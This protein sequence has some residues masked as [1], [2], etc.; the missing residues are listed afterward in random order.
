[1]TVFDFRSYKDFLLRLLADTPKSGWGMRSKFASACGCQ[2][3]YFSRVLKGSAQLSLEQAELLARHLRM[4]EDEL[5][6]FLLLVELERAGTKSLKTI[7]EKKIRKTLEQR[8]VLQ[9]RFKL[10][11]QL[12]PEEESRYYSNWVYS[13]AHVMLSIPQLQSRQKMATALGLSPNKMNEVLSFLLSAGF[14]SETDGKLRIG[15]NRVHVGKDSPLLSKHLTNWR[16]RSLYSLEQGD[17]ENFHYTGVVTLSQEDCLR[18]REILIQ[19]IEK[20][21]ALIE[22]SPEEVAYCLSLDFFPALVNR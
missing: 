12:T 3:A 1:M 19:A 22:K 8:M 20:A 21:N 18:I 6:F 10:K 17:Q 16:L 14:A 2:T 13:A 9:E 4:T 5:D 11:S 15:K 7:W